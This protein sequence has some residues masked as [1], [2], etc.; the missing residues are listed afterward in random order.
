MG[1]I[2]TPHTPLKGSRH[3]A[4]RDECVF[5]II[6]ASRHMAG[7][8]SGGSGGIDT[9]RAPVA[10]VSVTSFPDESQFESVKKQRFSVT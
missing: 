10:G 5:S 3:M 4:R 8:F 9:P 2:Y 1:G 6:F 7:A